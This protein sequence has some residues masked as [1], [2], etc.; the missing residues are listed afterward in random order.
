MKEANLVLQIMEEVPVKM[1]LFRRRKRD[2][3]ILMMVCS[4]YC[5]AGVP[6]LTQAG[7]TQLAFLSLAL[8]IG[9]GIVIPFGHVVYAA[10]L[11]NEMKD[12]QE[13]ISLSPEPKANQ[14]FLDDT[15]R[16]ERAG[17][18]GPD[19]FSFISTVYCFLWS[20]MLWGNEDSVG[21]VIVAMLIC[22]FSWF[23]LLH[24][25]SENNFR[26]IVVGKK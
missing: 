16:A 3:F 8:V 1:R 7:M 21:M 17:K 19:N 22:V 18:I 23:L 26:P 11:H 15:V 14:K 10:L 4:I 6:S 24:D 2:L 13:S 12:L 20:A 25:F 5:L 9:S